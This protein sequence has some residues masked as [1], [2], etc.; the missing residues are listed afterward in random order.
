LEQIDENLSDVSVDSDELEG[1]LN[2]SDDE[3]AEVGK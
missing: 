2:L 1:D 3:D